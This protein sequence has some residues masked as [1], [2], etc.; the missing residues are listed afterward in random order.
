M[1]SLESVGRWGQSAGSCLRATT[2]HFAWASRVC[3]NSPRCFNRLP[4]RTAAGE[5]AAEGRTA[6]L[7]FSRK[8]SAHRLW[9]LLAARLRMKHFPGRLTFDMSGSRRRATPA[10]DCPLDGG[11]SRHFARRAT[12][13]A[14][15]PP[16]EPNRLAR[17]LFRLSLPQSLCHTEREAHG[18][19]HLVR[20]CGGLG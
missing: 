16:R 5:R 8:G 18:L 9:S 3:S 17:C 4:S 10:A 15:R 14:H 6:R 12:E 7:S 19:V 1:A 2:T 20:A 13:P 11:V